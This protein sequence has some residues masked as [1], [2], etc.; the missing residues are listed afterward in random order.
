MKRKSIFAVAILLMLIITL[1]FVST[2]QTAFCAEFS[3]YTYI[4]V[5]PNPVG[6]GQ[7]VLVAYWLSRSPP[8]ASGAQ[9]ER[10]QNLTVTITKPN[11]AIQTMGP[12]ESDS[13]GSGWFE[14]T[15]DEI[16]T[17]FMQAKF[18]GQWIYRD[19]QQRPLPIPEYYKAS[20][21]TNFSIT[22]QQEPIP[23]T[24]TAALPTEY[25]DRPIE[26][27][28][29]E[30]Y[31]LAS[32]WLQG[33]YGPY[34]EY[35]PV[36]PAP[37][38]PHIMWTKEL[39]F[40]GVIG[41]EYGDTSYYQGMSYERQFT[42]PVIIN[43][44][45]YYNSPNFPKYGMHCV[46]LRTGETIWWQNLTS[47]YTTDARG[48]Q[49]YPTLTMGQ[50]LDYNSP[51]QHGG[52]PYL[53]SI[54]GSTWKMYD[55]FTGNW[56]LDLANAT[57]G[58][59]SVM[60]EPSPGSSET[61]GE[62]LYYILSGSG[63]WLAMWNSTLAIPPAGTSGSSF[64]Q[65]R[66]PQGATLDWQ[67]GIQWNK[68]I[69]D[70]PG[71]QSF[72]SA[73]PGQQLRPMNGSMVL[74]VASI[75]ATNT[76]PF[77]I[78]LMAYDLIEGRQMW[79]PFNLTDWPDDSGRAPN[80]T[81]IIDGCFAGFARDPMVWVGFDANTGRKIWGPT[82]PYQNGFGTYLSGIVCAYGN[83]YTTA[84]D[85]ML[86]CY[87]IKTGNNT[88]SFWTGS[89]GYDT[90][91]GTYPF[92]GDI[93]GQILAADGKIY[94][95]VGEH[96]PTQPMFKGA[97]LYC[98]DAYT[99]QQTWA[100]LGWFHAGAPVLADGYMV[101]F[102]GYDNRIYCFGKGPSATTLQ[103]PMTAVT[104][105]DSVVIQGT[106]TDI[107]AGT[108]QRQQAERYPNGVPAISDA[109]MTQWMEYLYMQKPMPTNVTGV[110]VTIEALD[111]NNNLIRI[112][113]VTS[114]SSGYFNFIWITPNVPGAYNVFAKFAGSE[115]Y[116]PS[117]A[118]TTMLVSEAPAAT[119]SPQDQVQTDYM[120]P[121]VG[122][123]I[124]VIIAVAIVGLL[125]LRK[126]P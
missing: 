123:A 101:S 45:L 89:S 94:A 36:G 65:W 110:E 26:A 76:T 55:A 108:K 92:G 21:S 43:G 97:R 96:S 88:W 25:W 113:S 83:L 86:R 57:G 72:A 41:G 2:F 107:A 117:Q 22:V 119:E 42:P 48:G 28:N 93:G 10:W 118:Y 68:T 90:P 13:V 91:Y 14:F 79:G 15:P 115:S 104:V 11:G 46:D 78:E 6:V 77:T 64:W 54:F 9:G 109:S 87:D 66:P 52:I 59:I 82:E 31:T 40:G 56:I 105:G 114:D 50:I 16:G 49:S 126:R 80:F 47:Q 120:L 61:G 3:T 12:Y 39:G 34:G 44:R 125:I 95:V 84:Y 19:S 17:W 71:V 37:N 70:V 24:S 20:V 62:I 27:Q 1:T 122:S 4:S 106:V 116:G 81:P 73:I 85:G 124:A 99:G 67:K 32:N 38:T 33:Q 5:R 58:G 100:I 35:V 63:N 60:S 53:W 8:S 98:V 7:P 69:P 111:P 18:P 74:A 29:R 121:I 23:Q 103:A 51:N 102:N 112:G 75:A 30:W